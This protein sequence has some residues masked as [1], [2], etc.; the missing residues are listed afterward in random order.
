MQLLDQPPAA[1]QGP[2]R[3]PGQYVFVFLLYMPVHGYH[4]RGIANMCTILQHVHLSCTAVRLVA[5]FT[6]VCDPARRVEY[7]NSIYQVHHVYRAQ[8][9]EK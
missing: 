4:V 3:D 2:L 9:M 8:S 6:S 5:L 1:G 7:T